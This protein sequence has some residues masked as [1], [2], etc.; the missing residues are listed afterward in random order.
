MHIS[1]LYF[2]PTVKLFLNKIP[3]ARAYHPK[4]KVRVLV[5]PDQRCLDKRPQ[6]LGR[7]VS[8]YHHLLLTLGSVPDPRE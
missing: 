2:G 3:K 4:Q 1:I 7:I 8:G 6:L 5:A